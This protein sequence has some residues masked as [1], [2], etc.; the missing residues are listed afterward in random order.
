VTTLAAHALLR[1]SEELDASRKPRVADALKRADAWLDAHVARAPSADVNSFAQ[2]YYL[3]YALDRLA[4]GR[5]TK[6]DVEDAVRQLAGG[7]CANGG[8]SYSKSFGD[9]WA[10]GF[11]GWP[12]TDRGRAHGMNT[13]LALCAL[14]RAKTAGFA[15]DDGVIATGV[16]ALKSMRVK[17]GVYTYTWPVPRNFES[18][19]ASAAR[20][21]VCEQALLRLGKSTKADMHET[22]GVFLKHRQDLHAAVKVSPSWMPPHAY[23]AYFFQFAYYHAASALAELG[24]VA[25]KKDLATLRDDLLGWAEPDGTWV[26]DLATGKSYGTASTLLVLK[27]AG[28]TPKK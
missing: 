16:E 10:G 7:L 4:A 6:G 26:D 24:D 14:A 22:L 27:L 5:G 20:A 1:W 28:T 9:R 19:D 18:D 12:K 3:D 15:V 17:C 21:P 13:G 25:S 23:S 2:A 11:A 8:W